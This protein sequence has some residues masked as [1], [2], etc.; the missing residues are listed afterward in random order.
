MDR[1]GKPDF[2]SAGLERTGSTWLH[3]V[4]RAH[5]HAAVTPFKELRYFIQR[6]HLNGGNLLTNWFHPHWHF[7][8]MKGYLRGTIIRHARALKHGG[9]DADRL[10]WDLHYLFGFRTDGWYRK[11]FHPTKVSGDLTPTYHFLSNDAVRDMARRFPQTKVILILRDPIDRAWSKYKMLMFDKD[12]IEATPE[13][14]ARDDSEIVQRMVNEVPD[15]GE[16]VAFWE[17]QFRGRFLL[18]FYEDLAA[19]PQ[20]YADTVS[21]FLGLPTFTLPDTF[22]RGKSTKLGS[23]PIPERIERNWAGQFQ[24]MLERF[25]DYD[26]PHP[27]SWREHCRRVLATPAIES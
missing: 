8:V 5:P 19:K 4:L 9:L 21:D 2:I 20:E 11:L 7:K 1:E 14:A 17:E 16:L 10:R 13:Q 25:P 27:E 24:P 3:K 18:L 15:Y 22:Q 6:E 23:M 26:S 12:Q